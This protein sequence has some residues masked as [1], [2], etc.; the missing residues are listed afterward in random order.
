MRSYLI[1]LSYLS[2]MP[3]DVQVEPTKEEVAGSRVWYPLVGLFLGLLLA[4]VMAL[5]IGMGAP[6]VAA[7][8][9]LAAWVGLTGGLHLDGLSDLADALA[10][11]ATPEQRLKILKDPHVG[12]FGIIAIALA[13]LGKL[14]ALIELIAADTG[15]SLLA[16]VAACVTAR[17]LLPVLAAGARY[18]RKEG[19]G[20]TI[21]EATT[22][23]DARRGLIIAA[24]LAAL[25]VLNPSLT[26]LWWLCLLWG[27]PVIIILGL[28]QTCVDQL[29]GVT[30]DCLGAAIE[31]IET[32]F[33]LLAVLAIR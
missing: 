10:G 3:V 4:G 30:G 27:L 33:L 2:A 8:L 22:W 25:L 5:G 20:Q 31:I 6:L 26:A 7:F 9:T 15:L 28:R 11:G 1:A 24:I 17:S 21:I 18:P 29:G 16:I 13:L 19:T 32:L 14:T 12:N 23:K